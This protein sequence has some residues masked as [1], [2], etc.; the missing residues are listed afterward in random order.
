M[1]RSGVG[2]LGSILMGF[3]AGTQGRLN[4]IVAFEEQQRSR[5]L[6]QQLA[7]AELIQRD[8]QRTVQEGQLKL[9]EKREERVALAEEEKLK[10]QN[11]DEQRKVLADLAKNPSREARIA[12]GRGYEALL[13]KRGLSPGPGFVESFQA[14]PVDEKD[15]KSI[16][17]MVLSGLPPEQVAQM[18]GVPLPL[19]TA[20]DKALKSGDAQVT[21][22]LTGKTPNEI[23]LDEM[24]IREAE[25][26]IVQKEMKI[27][28]PGTSKE[29]VDAALTIVGPDGKK[30]HRLMDLPPEYRAKAADRAQANAILRAQA[31]VANQPVNPQ[32]VAELSQ[33][34][35][36]AQQAQK[37]HALITNPKQFEVVKP[38][39][40]PTT[41]GLAGLRRWATEQGPEELSGGP[42]PQELIELR[43][44]ISA[45]FNLEAKI[46]SGAAV[47]APEEARLMG[48]LPSLERDKPE[49]LKAKLKD[50]ADYATVLNERTKRY[51]SVAGRGALTA[52]ADAMLR[53]QIIREV[54]F[55]GPKVRLTD[56]NWT[57]P[58]EKK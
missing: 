49:R 45:V 34:E 6:T 11:E 28:D 14:Q 9:A 26:D 32:Q 7:L 18:Q 43:Q 21:K 25:L 12:A 52:D 20:L 31:G 4:P 22:M 29:V 27:S 56:P 33:V 10:L 55:G 48:E 30:G 54:P 53:A 39:I 13:T 46:R 3:A 35:R 15:M 19:V 44:S 17:G 1:P 40:G 57:T 8:R 51:M 36:F 41:A 16:A 23:R 47:T 5:A 37:G 38:F 24:K 42:I 58:P 50:W 2:D